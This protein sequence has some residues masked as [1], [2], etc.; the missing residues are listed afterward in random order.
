MDRNKYGTLCPDPVKFRDYTGIAQAN[1]AFIKVIWI[2][3][4]DKKGRKYFI[5]VSLLEPE[6][7][8]LTLKLG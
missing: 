4:R 8:S 5:T 1:M 7:E 3:R 6:I 2:Q